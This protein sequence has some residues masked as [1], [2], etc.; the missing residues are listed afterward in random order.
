MGNDASTAMAVVN[1]KKQFQS[2]MNEIND[3]VN[4]QPKSE[5]DKLGPAN[6]KEQ[7]TRR[8]ER[9]DEYKDKQE[10]RAIRKAK[11][12]QQWSSHRQ[13]NTVPVKKGFFGSAAK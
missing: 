6:R 9:E 4:G 1:A 11:L 13:D 10:A 5:T 2:G 12:E 7:D 8:K 3:K